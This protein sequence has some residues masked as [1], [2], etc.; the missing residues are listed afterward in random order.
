MGVKVSNRTVRLGT[1]IVSKK[2][3]KNEV[4]KYQCA[5]FKGIKATGKWGENRL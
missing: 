4:E 5:T 1:K 3:N 2:R